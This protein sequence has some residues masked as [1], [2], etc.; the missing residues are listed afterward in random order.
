MVC[1]LLSARFTSLYPF[2]GSLGVYPS[3]PEPGL[4]P[5]M[6]G[7]SVGFPLFSDAGFS[8]NATHSEKLEIFLGTVLC[9]N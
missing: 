9:L 1:I 5:Q 6:Q 8:T 2:R 3:A 4:G 7:N